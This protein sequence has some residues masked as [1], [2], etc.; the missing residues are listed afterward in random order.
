M[1]FKKQLIMGGLFMLTL[2]SCGTIKNSEYE[3]FST[4]MHKII[5]DFVGNDNQNANRC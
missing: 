2:T 4:K 3:E 1:K 5:N